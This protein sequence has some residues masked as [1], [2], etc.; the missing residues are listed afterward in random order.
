MKK[1]SLRRILGCA[2][3]IAT[4][5]PMAWTQTVTGSITGE[6]EDASGAVV[7]GAVVTAHNLDTDV[8]T[9]TKTNAAGS[10]RIEFLPIGHYTVTIEASGFNKQTV[11]RW[12]CCR[13]RPSTSNWR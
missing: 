10:Y 6:V 11:P 7:P 13:P 8:N 4:C 12:R 5:L 9:S 2:F 1:K 3:A